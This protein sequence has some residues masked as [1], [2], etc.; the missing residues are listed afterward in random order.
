MVFWF[1][2]HS[3]RI[4]CFID[5]LPLQQYIQI[6][7]RQVPL[8]LPTRTYSQI[9]DFNDSH[10]SATRNVLEI[11]TGKGKPLKAII[12]SFPKAQILGIDINKK[13]VNSCQIFFQ[14]N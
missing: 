3:N 14:D 5:K 9:D 7:L 12:G 13:K 10:Q 1:Y 6:L 4:D 8:S 11:G 2:H